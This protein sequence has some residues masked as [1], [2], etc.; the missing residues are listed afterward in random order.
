MVGLSYSLAAK[1]LDRFLVSLRP[2]KI[3]I[4][5]GYGRDNGFGRHGLREGW[6]TKGSSDL[7]DRWAMGGDGGS[8]GSGDSVLPQGLLYI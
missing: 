8:M 2:P 3:M 7:I 1:T 6:E 4:G 5:C